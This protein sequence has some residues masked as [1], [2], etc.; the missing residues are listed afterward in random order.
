MDALFNTIPPDHINQSQF[1]EIKMSKPEW[2]NKYLRMKPEVTQLFDELDE[3][4]RAH[5]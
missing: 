2:L 4:G 3:I 1:E 5:V